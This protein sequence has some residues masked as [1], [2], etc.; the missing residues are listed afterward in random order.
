M[1]NNSVGAFGFTFVII[2]A[3]VTKAKMYTNLLTL[4]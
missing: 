1:S 4:N 2:I 3:F